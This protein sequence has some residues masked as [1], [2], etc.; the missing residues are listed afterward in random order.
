MDLEQKAF[1]IR[2]YRRAKH[3]VQEEMDRTSSEQD[4]EAYNMFYN[5]MLIVDR[6][7]EALEA[8][9]ESVVLDGCSASLGGLDGVEVG[10]AAGSLGGGPEEHL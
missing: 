5:Y 7:L 1:Q 3:D 9:I 6:R 10:H 8:P 2:V 4:W